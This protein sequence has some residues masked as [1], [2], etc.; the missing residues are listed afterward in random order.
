MQYMTEIYPMTSREACTEIDRLLKF[1]L[2]YY[3]DTIGEA[4]TYHEIEGRSYQLTD[5]T[6]Q[7]VNMDIEQITQSLNTVVRNLQMLE[8]EVSTVTT[9][10]ERLHKAEQEIV[11]LENSLGNAL[12]QLRDATNFINEFRSEQNQKQKDDDK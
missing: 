8:R 11:Y 9:M 10:S 1:L 2:H 6:Q 3:G 7:T 12:S 5:N 4:E